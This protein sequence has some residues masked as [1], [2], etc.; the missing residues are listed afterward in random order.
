MNLTPPPPSHYYYYYY[1]YYCGWVCIVCGGAVRA[2]RLLVRGAYHS[3]QLEGR[4][5]AVQDAAST[6]ASRY[7][8][9]VGLMF[10]GKR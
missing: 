6:A 7:I 4:C 5:P 9:P 10:F 3:G 8:S 2:G 1:Y